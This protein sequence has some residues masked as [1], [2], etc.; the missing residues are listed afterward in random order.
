[1]LN[2]KAGRSYDEKHELTLVLEEI[3]KLAEQEKMDDLATT[4][5]D[6]S[7][8]SDGSDEFKEDE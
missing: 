6:N 5:K 3:R 8:I 7:N 2:K 4:S 1:M